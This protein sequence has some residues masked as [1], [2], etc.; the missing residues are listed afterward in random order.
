MFQFQ[1]NFLLKPAAI[2]PDAAK[3]ATT[4]HLKSRML[5]D[6]RSKKCANKPQNRTLAAGV[7]RL[8]PGGLNLGKIS[9]KGY[10]TASPK[11]S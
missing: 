6:R 3:P 5:R 2:M 7:P 10:P 11:S 4:N 9:G 1:S 8:Q